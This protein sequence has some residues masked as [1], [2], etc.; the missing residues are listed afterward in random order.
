MD[1]LTHTVTGLFLSRAGLKRFTPLAT[2]ILMLAANAPD[3]DVV[4]FAG[5]NLSYLHYHRYLTHSLVAMP[6]MAIF[7]VLAVR[8]VARKPVRW[9]GAFGIALV[10]VLSHLLL[11]LT[12]VYGVRLLLPFSAKWL[13]LDLTSV[14]DL[15]IWAVVLL[16]LIGLVIA[17]LVGSEIT[18]GAQRNRHYGRGFAVFGLLFLLLYNCGRNVLHARAVASLDSRIYQESSPIR[19][20]A[21][22]DPANPLKWHGIVETGDFYAATD[23]NLLADFDPTRAVIFHKPDPDPALDAARRSEV[24]EQFLRFSQYPLWRVSPVSDPENGKLVQIYD[25]RFGTPLAPGIM[26]SALVNGKLQ[27]VDAQFQWGRPR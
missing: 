11:D 17:G 24:F 8:G 23:L 25:L 19:S 16:G 9:W 22:P 2:P 20:A 26:V 1:P 12:N 10:A 13:H 21:F 3:I 18:S 7:S 27:V 5:G 15:W 14:F 6:V 4:S